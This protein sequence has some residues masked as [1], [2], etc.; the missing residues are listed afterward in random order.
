MH[1]TSNGTSW[2]C[3]LNHVKSPI[4]SL[5]VGSKCDFN[6]NYLIKVL[7]KHLLIFIILRKLA[8]VLPTHDTSNGTSWF[9]LLNYVKSPLIYLSVESKCQFS[10]SYLIKLLAK[11]LLI[12]V[13]L[14]KLAFVLL[15]HDTPNGTSWFSQCKELMSFQYQLFN[16]SVSRRPINLCYIVQASICSLSS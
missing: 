3:L 9:C 8:F 4:I 14:R 2:F 10:T 13:T 12:F 16:K 5:S 11:D 6:T 7:A 15:V 1:D